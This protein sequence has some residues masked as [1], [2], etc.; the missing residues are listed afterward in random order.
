MWMEQLEEDVRHPICDKSIPP[1]VKGYINNMI[2]QP[3]MLHG[4]ETLQGAR[5]HVE[6]LEVTE[7]KMYT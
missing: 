2:V 1:Q 3:A 6:K 4:M 7:M 5:S